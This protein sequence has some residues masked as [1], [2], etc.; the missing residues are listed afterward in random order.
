VRGVAAVEVDVDP[1]LHHLGFADPEE[2]EGDAGLAVG[3]LDHHLV[4]LL[5]G[6]RPAGG[7]GPEPGQRRVVGGV[8]D[9]GVQA[10]AHRW[11]P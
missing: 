4:G 9:D 8:D 6:D 7:P 2:D 5:Q 1:V 3:R 11:R 10:G